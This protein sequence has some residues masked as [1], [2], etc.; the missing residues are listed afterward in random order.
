LLLGGS[1]GNE[2]SFTTVQGD[3]LEWTIPDGIRL[4]GTVALSMRASP[5]SEL[6][7]LF[8]ADA[9]NRMWTSFIIGTRYSLTF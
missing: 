6:S 1:C 8:G 4:K 3:P 5:Y 7:V 2:Y 9:Y